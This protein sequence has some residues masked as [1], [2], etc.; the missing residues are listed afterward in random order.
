MVKERLRWSNIFNVPMNPA[1]PPNFPPKTLNI[2]RALTPLS[3]A[4]LTTALDKLWEEFFVKHT[5]TNDPTELE[6]I[7]PGAQAK[8]TEADKKLLSERTEE[9]FR[10]GAFGLPWMVCTNDK[11]ETEGFW[12]VDHFGQ[13]CNFLGLERPG[14]GGW[15]ALL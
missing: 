11:G 5:A 8:V 15:K 4:D 12:G 13:V 3:Q 1:T 14:A 7:L 10:A 9:A 6:R 2:M